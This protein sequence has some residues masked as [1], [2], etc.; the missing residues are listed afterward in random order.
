M[1][2]MTEDELR[3]FVANT[4]ASRQSIQ[5]FVS[6]VAANERAKEVKNTKGDKALSEL[7]N[8]F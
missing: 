7:S 4:R 8:L 2:Q 3:E 5:T 1:D 6:R